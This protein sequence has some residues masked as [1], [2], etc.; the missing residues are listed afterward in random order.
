V[1]A[2]VFPL[3]HLVD[4]LYIFFT[5]AT[6]LFTIVLHASVKPVTETFSVDKQAKTVAI[7][8][9]LPGMEV[10]ASCRCSRISS[11]V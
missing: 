5:T 2:V 4:I 11:S 8:Q 1:S 10:M 9:T 6:L 7:N 3:G